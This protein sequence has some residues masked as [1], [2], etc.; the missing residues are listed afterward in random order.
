MIAPRWRPFV[1]C[2]TLTIAMAT[3]ATRADHT[4]APL[5]L[6]ATVSGMAVTLT[7]RAGG[8]PPARFIVEVGSHSGLSNIAVISLPW[9]SISGVNGRVTG[10]APPGRYYI[11]VRA[12]EGNT[13][14]PASNEVVADVGGSCSPLPAPSSL[15]ATVSGASIVVRWNGV[16]GATAYVLEGG[17]AAGSANLGM[18][19]L[20]SSS[21]TFTFD[22]PAGR[23]F[24]RLRS[25]GACGAGQP[26]ADVE[27]VVGAPTGAILDELNG[28]TLG[29]PAG[30]SYVATPS[31][32]GARFTSA[33]ESRIRYPQ[34]PPEGTLEWVAR[35]DNGYAYQAGRFTPRTSTALLFT[36]DCGGGDVTWPGSAWL[37]LHQDGTVE[38]NLATVKYQS[39]PAIRLR[40]AQTGFAFGSWHLLGVSYGARGVQ[41]MVDGRVV[42]STPTP[43]RLGAG[44][45]HEQPVDVAT[46]GEAPCGFWRNNQ[47]EAGFD[48][49]VDRLRI[50][51]RELD[52]GLPLP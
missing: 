37:W 39:P 28:T 13:T 29:V 6:T 46:V 8:S 9:G 49:V 51:R 24:L 14:G 31:G 15:T 2:A 17:T 26:S 42:A 35:V 21:T 7:W 41:V 19:T 18:V 47:Y 44:G 12:R 27:V 52:W 33:T 11:R 16:A 45:T 25:A 3:S 30:I 32:L 20:P 43:V 22:A 1:A 5:N 40:A 4:S 50:S 34:V 23:Y 38:F 48:G 36:T 10:S